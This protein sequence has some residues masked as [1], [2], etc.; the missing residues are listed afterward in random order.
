M[1]CPTVAGGRRRPGPPR[2][3]DKKPAQPLGVVARHR[4]ASKWPFPGTGTG[5][6]DREYLPSHG[7]ET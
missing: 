1:N 4:K 7:E 3:L 5:R 2:W 6:S